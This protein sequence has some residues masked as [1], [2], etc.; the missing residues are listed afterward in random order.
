MGRI[1]FCLTLSSCAVVAECGRHRAA[2]H[3]RA[4]ASSRV[5]ALLTWKSRLPGRQA[6][7]PTK[8]A[9]DT[10]RPTHQGLRPC[11]SAGRQEPAAQG[12]YHPW[13]SIVCTQT[14]WDP[15]R[16]SVSRR[17]SPPAPS[18]HT[19]VPPQAVYSPT[20]VLLIGWMR[21]AGMFKLTSAQFPAARLALRIEQ[22]SPRSTDSAPDGA[23]HRRPS[24]ASQPFAEHAYY[25]SHARRCC[26][27]A[28]C[29]QRPYAHSSIDLSCLVQ[30]GTCTAKR[31]VRQEVV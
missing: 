8:I 17:S 19:R 10:G 4:M 11:S 18:A 21:V 1:A 12:S 22:R 9:S 30:L 24:Y 31:S 7:R 2:R 6:Q 27:G 14:C 5:P 23:A 20:R 16:P 26:H 28:E 25:L 3:D 29:D 15:C 13:A